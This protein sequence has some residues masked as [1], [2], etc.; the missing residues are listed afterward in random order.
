MHKN[1]TKCNKMQSKWCIN[2]HGASKIIDTFETYQRPAARVQRLYKAPPP[3]TP[4]THTRRRSAFTP[5]ENTM[6]GR[7]PFSRKT[8]HDG[9]ASGSA[10]RDRDW[11]SRDRDRC[12]MPPPRQLHPSPAALLPNGRIHAAAQTRRGHRV[13]RGPCATAS[14]CRSSLLVRST[15]VANSSLGWT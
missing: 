1:A 7:W 12:Q 9:E 14:M 3:C 4:A 11:A 5:Y 10:S 8:K 6:K 15:P 13:H 2:K